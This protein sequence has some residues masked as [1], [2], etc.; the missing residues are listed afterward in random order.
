M[1]LGRSTE[2]REGHEGWRTAPGSAPSEAALVYLGGNWK[3]LR[4]RE[5]QPSA[6][7]TQPR[8]SDC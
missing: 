5:A 7:V 1:T 3:G 2:P 4:P 8:Q 6:A